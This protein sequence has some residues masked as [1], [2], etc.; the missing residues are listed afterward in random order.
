MKQF[1]FNSI[2]QKK[3][4]SFYCYNWNYKKT[5][6]MEKNSF[7]ASSVGVVACGLIGAFLDSVDFPETIEGALSVVIANVATISIISI[8]A[9]GVNAHPS[10]YVA[11]GGFLLIAQKRNSEIIS[12]Q[13]K[14]LISPGPHFRT[15][16]TEYQPT[17]S[18]G[19][20]C[21]VSAK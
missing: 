1:G 6:Q 18:S 12:N 14:H 15:P 5:N 17:G 16:I 4:N 21:D 3:K 7:V 13:L 11:A 8:T 10:F 20:S 9:L 19:Q 2:A